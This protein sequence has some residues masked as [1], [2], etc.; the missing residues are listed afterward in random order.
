MRVDVCIKH[1]Y[2]GVRFP[3]SPPRKPRKG[4]LPWR[5]ENMNCFMFVG[6]EQR[7]HVSSAEETDEL[8]PRAK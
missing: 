3:P 7:S 8:V 1:N 6:I 5:W 2:T 4:F